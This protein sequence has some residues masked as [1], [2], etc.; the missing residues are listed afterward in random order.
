MIHM[1]QIYRIKWMHEREGLSQRQ[2]VQ[3]LG[4]SRNTVAKYLAM[5]EIPA[6]L[7]RKKSYGH[8]RYGDEIM[9]V[10]PILEQWFQD[11]E[12]AWK[13]QHH[14]ATR[15]YERLVKEYD[16]KG[17]ASNVRRVVARCKQTLKEVFI[18]LEFQLGH[19]FQVDWGKADVLFQ[20]KLTR[21]HL[22]CVE[23]AAS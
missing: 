2:I 11:D 8:R 6:P 19:Q 16:F 10:L 14:T 22:F 4:L 23:L 9:R 13:K 5:D 3:Q 21:V 12:S 15:M 7:T 17:S 20:G 1:A 18:P